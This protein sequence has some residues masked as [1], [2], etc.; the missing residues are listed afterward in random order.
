MLKATYNSL[1]PSIIK[2]QNRLQKEALRKALAT[3]CNRVLRVTMPNSVSGIDKRKTPGTSALAKQRSRIRKDILGNNKL[4]EGLRTAIPTGAGGFVPKSFKGFSLMPFIVYSQKGRKKRKGAPLR[5]FISSADELV[6]FIRSSTYLSVKKGVA[7]RRAKPGQKLIW[8][9]L[10]TARAA[11]AKLVECSGYLMSGWHALARLSG[12]V[13]FSKVVAKRK[14][15]NGSGSATLKLDGDLLDLT[16]RNDSV[17]GN[18]KVQ[19]YQIGVVEEFVPTAFYNALKNEEYYATEAL[20]KF[21]K[22]LK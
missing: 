9:N 15:S 19:K 20:N 12:T 22:A 5:G 1:L 6:R 14:S 18:K 7:H 16:A 17:P 13:L 10:K 3:T 2:E 11:A 8:T 21:I 4:G